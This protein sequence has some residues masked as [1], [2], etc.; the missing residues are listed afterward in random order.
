MPLG[1]RLAAK[2]TGQVVRGGPIGEGAEPLHAVRAVE[3]GAAGRRRLWGQRDPEWSV[4][5]TAVWES[6]RGPSSGILLPSLQ[7]PGAHAAMRTYRCR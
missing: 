2:L 3:L 1:T 5:T 7:L 6:G 4:V